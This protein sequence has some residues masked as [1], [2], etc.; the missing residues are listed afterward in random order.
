MEAYMGNTAQKIEPY[1]YQEY[2]ENHGDERLEIIDGT[3][4]DMSPSTMLSMLRMPIS[5]SG[6]RKN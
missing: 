5:R 4:Y 3:V 6:W 1:T 2:L